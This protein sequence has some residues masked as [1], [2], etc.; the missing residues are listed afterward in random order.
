MK[1]SDFMASLA[2]CQW[3]KDSLA[4][5]TDATYPAYLKVLPQDPKLPS[6]YSY[7]YIS[8]GQHFQVLVSLESKNS[9]EYKAAIAKRNILCGKKVCNAG[10]ASGSTPL[11]RSIEEY[12]KELLQK[13]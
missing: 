8:S 1:L 4:D 5:I 7:F 13:K 2:P 11:D 3:G 12:E 9:D 10:R 6:G